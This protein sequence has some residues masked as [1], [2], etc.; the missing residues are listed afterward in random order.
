MKDTAGVARSDEP[1]LLDPITV[2]AFFVDYVKWMH[3]PP[4]WDV[5]PTEDQISV[6]QVLVADHVSPYVAM[7]LFGA[8]WLA[9]AAQHQAFRRDPRYQWLVAAP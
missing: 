5:E 8:P 6:V 9:H 3:R 4:P 2:T 1:P 7:S